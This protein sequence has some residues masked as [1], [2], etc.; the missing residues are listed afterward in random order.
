MLLLFFFYHNL[1]PVGEV[2]IA[3]PVTS[4]KFPDLHQNVA[5]L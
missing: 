5:L 2:E 4:Q 1:G 3:N